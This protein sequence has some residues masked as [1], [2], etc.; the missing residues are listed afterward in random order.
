[1]QNDTKQDKIIK[2]VLIFI[3]IVQVCAMVYAVSQRRRVTY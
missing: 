3:T 1:M 2:I